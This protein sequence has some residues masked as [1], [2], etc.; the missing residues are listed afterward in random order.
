MKAA[1][2][3]GAFKT[4]LNNIIAKKQPKEADGSSPLL[5]EAEPIRV[6]TAAIQST[7][8][9]QKGFKLFL[10][11]HNCKPRGNNHACS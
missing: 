8:E 5:R 6:K 10:C 7:E 2:P 4:E 1:L 9:E 3:R 11:M